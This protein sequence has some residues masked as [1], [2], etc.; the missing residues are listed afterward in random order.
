VLLAMVALTFDAADRRGAS[1]VLTTG[2]LDEP[3]HLAGGV[4]GL[5]VLSCSI[6]APRRFYVAGLIASVAID[7]N[8]VPLFFFGSG[9]R[10]SG[11][12]RIP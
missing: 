12:S 6:D 9:T 5:L 2:A 3:A 8:H 4:L 10:I 11:L 7:L 1:S